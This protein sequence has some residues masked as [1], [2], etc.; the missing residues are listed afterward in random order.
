MDHNNF[1]MSYSVDSKFESDK[2]VKIRCRVCH[3]GESPN[4]TY[5]TKE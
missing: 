1:V 5:F 4:K 2:F 3:D